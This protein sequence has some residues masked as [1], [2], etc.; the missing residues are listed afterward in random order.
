M[1]TVPNIIKSLI[2]PLVIKSSKLDVSSAPDEYWNKFVNDFIYYETNATPIYSKL[3]H[4]ELNDP[5]YIFNQLPEI[6]SIF[7]KE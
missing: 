1:T 2:I 3:Y 6:Y 4:L 7:M 5:E